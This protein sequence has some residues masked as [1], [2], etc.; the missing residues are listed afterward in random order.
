MNRI[1]LGAFVALLLVGVGL[2]WLQGRA[3]VEEG[4]PPPAAP[5]AR[6]TGLPV[7]DAAG[8]EGPPPPEASDLTREQRR[9]FR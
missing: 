5:R 2:F 8:L 3:E 9:F 4:A 7:A 6:P 1:V